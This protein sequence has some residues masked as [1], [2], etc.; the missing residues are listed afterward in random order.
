MG[1]LGFLKSVKCKGNFQTEKRERELEIS[2]TKRQ[3]KGD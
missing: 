3:R 2:H 1:L